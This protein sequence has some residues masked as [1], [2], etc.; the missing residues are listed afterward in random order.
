MKRGIVFDAGTARENLTA[1]R[2]ALA[3]IDKR[4]GYPRPGTD[5]GA[6]R[7]AGGVTRSAGKVVRLSGDAAACVVDEEAEALGMVAVDD[8][9]DPEDSKRRVS[10][11]VDATKATDIGTAWTRE[12][13]TLV[14]AGAL[15]D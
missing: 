6:G 13:A 5:V 12:E 10:V 1:A 2:R 9:T 3:A 15:E 8:V 7:H 14:R 11:E 4:L